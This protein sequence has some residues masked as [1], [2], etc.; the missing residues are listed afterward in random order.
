[1]SMSVQ[2]AGATMGQLALKNPVGSLGHAASTM[3]DWNKMEAAE[4]HSPVVLA[5]HIA[6]AGTMDGVGRSVNCL[7]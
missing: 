4:V 2:S 5:E 1:M 7:A 6:N 3:K